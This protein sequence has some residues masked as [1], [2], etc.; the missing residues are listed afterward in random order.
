MSPQEVSDE[1]VPDVKRV[2]TTFKL[3]NDTKEVPLD[4]ERVD[5]RTILIREVRLLVSSV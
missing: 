5:G 1:Q 3:A 4:H 2:G